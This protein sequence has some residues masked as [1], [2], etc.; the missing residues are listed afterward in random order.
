LDPDSVGFTIAALRSTVSG[1]GRYYSYVL[2][3]VKG[4][5][6]QY[7]GETRNPALPDTLQPDLDRSGVLKPD[8]AGVFS[9]TFHTVLPS[10]YDR[11]ATHVLAGELS[12][13]NGKYVAN[14]L[15]RF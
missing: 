7:R 5:Q 1:E 6:Y 11:N 4:K 10:D 2:T 13:G 9:Y 8:A 14:P 3:N 15:F 12:R